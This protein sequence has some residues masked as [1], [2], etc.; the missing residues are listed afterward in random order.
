MRLA[1][2]VE[3]SDHGKWPRRIGVLRVALAGLAILLVAVGWT[4]AGAA[5]AYFAL[6]CAGII[7]AALILG[8]PRALIQNSLALILIDSFLISVLVYYTGGGGSP[9]FP[10]YLL[11][12]L[13]IARGE[14]GASPYVGAGALVGGYL[15]VA[16]SSVDAVAE[17]FPASV[18]KAV[19]IAVFCLVAGYLGA[20]LRGL[21]EDA[22]SFSH[23]AASTRVGERHLTALVESLIPLLKVLDLEG[24]L[25][26]TA[27]VARDM[28]QA[29]YVH[30]AL[31]D[32]SRH[33]T[34]V[35]GDLEVY[36]SWWH[37]DVQRLVLWS[38]R[39]GDV[40]REEISLHGME[41]FVA[42]P[43]FSVEG[44]GLGSVIVGGRTLDAREEHALK[45]LAAV[46]ASVV[47]EADDASGGREPV[48]GLA[49]QASLKRSL[50]WELSQGNALTLLM[51]RLDRLQEYERLYG[52]AVSEQL[53]GK[54]GSR[55]K[56]EHHRVFRYGNSLAIVSKG[57]SRT[58]ARKA[59]LRVRQVVANLTD[60][61][62]VSLDASVG[63]LLVDSGKA[64]D[65]QLILD[66]A[67]DAVSRAENEPE[68]LFGAS[69]E[70]VMGIT[71]GEARE[72]EEGAV[73]ALLE[74]ARIR[75]PYL[76]QHMR[77]VSRLSLRVGYE[78]G[79]S[80][81]QM[82]DLRVGALLHD[83]GKI[84]ISDAI[85]QKSRALSHEEYDDIKKH[86]TL[87]AELVAKEAGLSG[88]VP[89]VKHHHER[90]D[91]KGYPD[92]LKGEDIP[93]TARIVCVV[94]AWD[95]MIRD[96]I[97]QRPISEQSAMD[98]IKRNS[99]TQ[100]DPRVVE[101]L[102]AVLERPE[103]WRMDYAN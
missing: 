28:L 48:S 82:H 100:F 52:I 13:G 7:G 50:E 74:A 72:R 46:V 64:K 45:L 81:E 35:E 10:F 6:V 62:A 67:A 92:G 42:V 77:A 73:L 89:A 5:A 40:L 41:D 68:K 32:G 96:K 95:S 27:R 22:R 49:N 58:R 43:I 88:A 26:W 59:A 8:R 11:A 44:W 78:M 84:G 3:Q 98:E 2:I 76:E 14:G 61:T 30:I 36:P 66:A 24:M 87:G 33:R 54:I 34:A 57:T 69:L 99:G 63:F 80:R 65:P 83:I 90:L 70:E 93:L 38:A 15:F 75:D 1:G 39:T 31:L 4:G 51:T 91:G 94:D 60:N 101:A 103:G 12:A 29:P 55:L 21:R 85:L 16:G 37:P 97:Y 102:I 20:V 9:F 79:L 47:D 53:F 86:T 18:F 25:E 71:E 56:E 23:A 19:L 17:L